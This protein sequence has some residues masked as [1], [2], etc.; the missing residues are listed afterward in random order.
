VEHNHAR[1]WDQAAAAAAGSKAT[2]SLPLSKQ[3]KDFSLFKS[4]GAD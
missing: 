3:A 1:R 4:V 2:F